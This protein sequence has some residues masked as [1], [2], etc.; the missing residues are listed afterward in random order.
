MANLNYLTPTR[1]DFS[2]SNKNHLSVQ[3]H[4]TPATT[5]EIPTKVDHHSHQFSSVD[6]GYLVTEAVKTSMS[7]SSVGST[8]THIMAAVIT[9]D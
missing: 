4:A 1:S 9:I 8:V 2:I 5:R 3:V 6:S 7:T